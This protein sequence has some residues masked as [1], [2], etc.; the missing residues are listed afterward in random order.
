M[1]DDEPRRFPAKKDRK[2]WCG[3]KEGREHV[4]ERRPPSPSLLGR[5]EIDVCA[6][7]GRKNWTTYR[8]LK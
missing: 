2:R 4:W 5:S 8:S 7:C 1:I 3:G 6:V